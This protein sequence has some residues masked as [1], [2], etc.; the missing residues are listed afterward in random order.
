MPK[1][2]DP[3]HQKRRSLARALTR[4]TR[5]AVEIFERSDDML[6]MQEESG[7]G[8]WI[9]IASS[10]HA[11]LFERIARNHF[12]GFEK[13]EYVSG[14]R[15]WVRFGFDYDGRVPQKLMEATAKSKKATAS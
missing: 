1:R 12:K 10:R 5:H 2:V 8:I 15:A 9:G 13:H 3:Q 7:L 14:D 4:F 6:L 11:E